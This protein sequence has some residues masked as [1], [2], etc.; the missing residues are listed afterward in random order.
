[1]Q[2]EVNKRASA[3]FLFVN[4]VMA[5]LYYWSFFMG[6]MLLFIFMMSDLDKD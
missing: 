5:D 6:G 3:L 1:M 2:S 4:F